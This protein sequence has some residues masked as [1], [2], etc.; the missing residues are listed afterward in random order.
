MKM[1]TFLSTL[2]L[3]LALVAP[4]PVFSAKTTKVIETNGRE[5]IDKIQCDA[6]VDLQL[7]VGEKHVFD[8]EMSSSENKYIVE[9]IKFWFYEDEDYNN[10]N[11]ILYEPTK[12]A[13]AAK[14]LISAKEMTV[15]RSKPYL[16]GH[17]PA[18]RSQ[19]NILIKYVISLDMLNKKGEITQRGTFTQCS[20]WAVT[21]CGDK[22][23]DTAYGE[24]CDDGP[25]GSATC[26][27][28]CKKIKK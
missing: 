20:R 15:M 5:E 25:A 7:R 8:V 21:S 9:D 22:I 18:K 16:V 24:E 13:L 27:K 14:G 26:S 2:A 3:T 23:T 1:R 19:E 6:S 17:A 10:G 12:E 28:Q 11:G 4:T